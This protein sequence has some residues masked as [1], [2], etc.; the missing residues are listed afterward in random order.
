MI[1]KLKWLVASPERIDT[2]IEEINFGSQP[3]VRFYTMVAAS[4]LIAAIGLTANS[5]AVIIGAMLVAPLMTPIFGISLALV[6]GN[7]V[8]LG[9]ALQ[10]EIL[11]VLLAVSISALF[12]ILPL[13]IEIT[14]EMLARTKP[15]L[16][17][18]LVAVLAGFAGAYALVDERIS[19]A[20]PGV[21][22]AT[23]I[24]P[25]LANT[26]LCLALG[27]YQGAT[28]SFLLFVANFLSILIV[29]SIIFILAGMTYKFKG[30]MTREV[31]RR[32]GI[33]TIGFLLVTAFL[34]H[35]LVGIV[36]DRNLRKT[37]EDVL[38][39]E[40]FRLHSTSLDKVIHDIYENKLYVMATV[41]IP[42][43]IS[44]YRVEEMQQALSQKVG[45][46]VE[47]IVRSILAKDIGATGSTDQVAIQNLDGIFLSNKISPKELNIKK[48]E[49][50][51]WEKLTFDPT[52]QL[53]DV[54]FI[55]APRGPVILS[56]MK[57]TR[58]LDAE[59]IQE[60]EKAIQDRLQDPTIHLIVNY[61]K[62]DVFDRR[63]KFLSE[64]SRYG[65]LTQ[66]KEKIMNQIDMDIKE[67]FKNYP[68]VFP[69]SVHFEIRGD[70]WNVM[71]EVVGTKVMSPNDLTNIEKAVSKKTNKVINISILFKSEIVITESG[72][73]SFEKLTDKKVLEKIKELK[74]LYDKDGD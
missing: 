33:A 37:I 53:I 60:L 43:I 73:T 20:L 47:L 71:V 65:P 2:V 50:V 39:T 57:G 41:H 22:I 42:E 18:L 49:Q 15:N 40:F 27:A 64:W 24:V 55:S 1:K 6:R 10:A 12:G 72:Y 5:T 59:E 48:A 34:T 23:A 3:G 36:K 58:P 38:Y 26:G 31:L 8:L 9:R 46:P 11:G 74:G 67:E 17:D 63:G 66:E 61:L 25:P 68:N 7:P 30:A 56:T 32:F 52:L 45:L 28:G 69:V 14:P 13:A 29:S 54:D 4:T 62:G 70:L 19:P 21:A 51:L 35:S 44:P 16:L